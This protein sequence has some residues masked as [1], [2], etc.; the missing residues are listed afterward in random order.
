[1]QKIST[2]VFVLKYYFAN[3]KWAKTNKKETL[4]LQILIRILTKFADQKLD[5]FLSNFA[6]R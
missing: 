6:F 5:Y 2:F 4:Y 3:F 1:M